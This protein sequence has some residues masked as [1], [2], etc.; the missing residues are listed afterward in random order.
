[1][2]KCA[3]LRAQNIHKRGYTFAEIMRRLISISV[4]LAAVLMALG[5]GAAFATGP[6]GIAPMQAALDAYTQF[7]FNRLRA[8]LQVEQITHAHNP[9]MFVSQMSAASYALDSNVYAT[10]AI[11]RQTRGRPNPGGRPIPY[12]PKDVWCARLNIDDSSSI[13]R[14]IFVAHHVDGAGEVWIVHDPS[15]AKGAARQIVDEVGCAP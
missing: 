4:F 1:M 9:Q 2:Q 3:G 5:V 6:G 11:M 14:Y 13:P 10:T 12:P 15:L 7:Q 8:T